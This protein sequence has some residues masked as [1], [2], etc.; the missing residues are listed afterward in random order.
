M[1]VDVLGGIA[2][3]IQEAGFLAT[4]DEVNKEVDIYTQS[5]IGSNLHINSPTIRFAVIQLVG[6]I[7][8]VEGLGAFGSHDD[9][10]IDLSDPKSIELILKFLHW[11]LENSSAAK[12]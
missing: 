10:D 11:L 7:A 8:I 5:T 9:K 4:V 1:S 2:E 6:T 3:A 12:T